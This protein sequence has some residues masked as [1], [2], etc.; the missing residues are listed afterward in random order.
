MERSV[1]KQA[2]RHCPFV[3]RFAR[4]GAQLRKLEMMRLVRCS[5]ADKAGQGGNELKV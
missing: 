3:T 2:K 1:M 4:Q 5:A